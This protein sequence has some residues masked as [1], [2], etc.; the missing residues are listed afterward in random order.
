MVTVATVTET[1]TASKMET[2]TAITRMQKPMIAH[3]PW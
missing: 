1:E 2:V 3:Q